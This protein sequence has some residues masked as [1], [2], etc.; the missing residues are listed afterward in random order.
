M[1]DGQ[2]VEAAYNRFLLVQTRGVIPRRNLGFDLRIVCPT[3]RWLIAVGAK[4]PV[5]RFCKVN[6]KTAR[7]KHLPAALAGRRF[8]DAPRD[9]RAPVH[10]SKV[11]LH[12]QPLQKVYGNVA[13]G[14]HVGN[15]RPTLTTLAN[16]A[17]SPGVPTHVNRTVGP[18]EPISPTP[19]TGWRA[20]Y[21]NA[22]WAIPIAAVTTLPRDAVRCTF[23]CARCPLRTQ[24]R[25]HGPFAGMAGQGARRADAC[26]IE[27]APRPSLQPRLYRGTGGGKIDDARPA[28][29]PGTTPLPV[30]AGR[31]SPRRIPTKRR[32]ASIS[33]HSRSP[34]R[35]NSLCRQQS[36]ISAENGDWVSGSVEYRRG[37]MSQKSGLS[38]RGTSVSLRS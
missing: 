29:R 37:R 14:F 21:C 13:P 23:R 18:W 3:I 11:D 5:V 4:G 1:I 30:C 20:L 19:V 8:L 16:S 36:A 12:V 31:A 38:A 2:P 27:V 28:S 32:A 6:A 17:V 33:K 22:Y 35:R 15:L 7:N 10:G 24:L 9:N 34:R 25:I 26:A